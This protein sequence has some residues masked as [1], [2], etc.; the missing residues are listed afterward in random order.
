MNDGLEDYLNSPEYAASEAIRDA[1]T[2]EQLEQLNR[3]QEAQLIV[4]KTTDAQG[5]AQI[6]Q[7]VYAVQMAA[8]ND[9]SASVENLVADAL[10]ILA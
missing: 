10:L 3:I 5:N 9:L 8:R 2:T 7:C 1:M 6:M 4:I